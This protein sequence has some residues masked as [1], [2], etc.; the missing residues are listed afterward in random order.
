MTKAARIKEPRAALVIDPH[1]GYAAAVRATLPGAAIAA[2]RPPEPGFVRGRGRARGVVADGA[3]GGPPRTTAVSLSANGSPRLRSQPF[4]PQRAARISATG[5]RGLVDL[6]AAGGQASVEGDVE[7]VEGGFPA[8][9]PA[10]SSGAAV[11][12]GR[13]PSR[14]G[15]DRAGAAWTITGRGE[16]TNGR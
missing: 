15:L 3:T 10:A 2:A 16:G 14:S 11:R 5:S 6:L 12:A 9:R 13:R 7:R 1:A 4:H 8:H